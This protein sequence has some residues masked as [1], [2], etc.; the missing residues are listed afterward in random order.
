[1]FRSLSLSF[2]L[3]RS[4]SPDASDEIPDLSRFHH[5]RESE[6]TA[7]GSSPH[8]DLAKE[9]P[10]TSYKGALPLNK[11]PPEEFRVPDNVLPQP[12]ITTQ[13]AHALLRLVSS[14]RDLRASLEQ[15][16]GIRRRVAE[17][18]A[19]RLA[20]E[21]AASPPTSEPACAEESKSSISGGAP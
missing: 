7:R 3:V 2:M 18:E 9:D 21:V 12:F 10:A 1:M 15:L 11:G 6:D 16:R 8:P 20:A 13:D 14:G 17:A 4:P 5:F 19:A